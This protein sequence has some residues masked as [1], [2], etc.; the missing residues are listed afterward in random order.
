MEAFLSG[1][2]SVITIA[3]MMAVGIF[4]EKRGWL[5]N[6]GEKILSKL[7]VNFGLPCTL[8]ASFTKNFIVC[9]NIYFK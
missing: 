4:I 2:Y 6:D 8:F 9:C 7:V 1:I 3:I 5:K